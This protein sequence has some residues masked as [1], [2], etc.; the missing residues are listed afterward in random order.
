MIINWF[1]IEGD[2]IYL[3]DLK[4]KK[5]SKYDV[6]KTKDKLLSLENDLD[7]V[8]NDIVH[9]KQYT[10]RF[11]EKILEKYGK[12]KD[13]KTKIEKFDT[14]KVKQAALTNKKLYID[15]EQ[16]FCGFSIKETD[17]IKKKHSFSWNDGFWQILYRE[18][19]IK[20]CG[21]RFYRYR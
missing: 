15:Y 21:F 20:K 19:T 11:F 13:R 7:E 8:V 5:I 1:I 12:E 6:E 14:I 10:I 18:I 9:I 2:V 17:E 3:T 4:I 16:G